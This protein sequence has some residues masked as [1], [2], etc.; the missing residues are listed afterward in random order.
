SGHT[1]NLG[2]RPHAGAAKTG[3]VKAPSAI[4]GGDRPRFRRGDEHEIAF[5]HAGDALA[6]SLVG[7]PHAAMRHGAAAETL[8]IGPVEREKALKRVAPFSPIDAV[9]DP[10]KRQKA[11]EDEVLVAP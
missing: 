11:G 7:H 9:L 2:D 10:V 4:R 6:R 8:V 5:A 1:L 3:I